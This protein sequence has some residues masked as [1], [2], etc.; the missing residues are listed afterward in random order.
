MDRTRLA[1]PLIALAAFAAVLAP[2]APALAHNSLAE[3]TPAKNATLKKAPAEVKLR[4]LQ[5]LNPDATNVAVT[6]ADK[7]PVPTAEPK[8]TAATVVIAFTDPPANGQYTV[9]YRVASTDGHAVQGSY[10]FTV[11]APVP[12]ASASASASAS[13][14]AAG[15][16]PASIVPSSGPAAAPAELASDE[17]V[18]RPIG[19][20]IVAGVMA[21]IVV[22][23]TGLLVSRRSRRG[24]PTG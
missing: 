6:D 18:S 3:A 4:F 1:R 21:V 5:K 17:K 15:P 22:A 2:A 16:S 10:K 8:V 13:S 20:W 23:L 12:A 24:D 14:T 7:K 11:A 19:A 9:A